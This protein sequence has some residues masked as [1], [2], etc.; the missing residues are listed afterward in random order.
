MVGGPVYD[1]RLAVDW[2]GS[3]R[4]RAKAYVELQC[5]PYDLR[6]GTTYGYDVGCRCDRCVSAHNEHRRKDYR[7]RRDA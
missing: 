6:H 5:F 7:K 3:Y 1:Y 4:S 2:G